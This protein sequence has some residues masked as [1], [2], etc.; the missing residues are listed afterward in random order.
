MTKTQAYF[1]IAIEAIILYFI[2]KFEGMNY[3]TYYILLRLL[4]SNILEKVKN[5]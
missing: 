5:D 1:L 4:F 2:N 3:A